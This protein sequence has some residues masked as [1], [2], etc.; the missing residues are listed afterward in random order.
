MTVNNYAPDFSRLN[1]LLGKVC[2][3]G[4]KQIVQDIAN[5][6]TIE[7]DPFVVRSAATYDMF[8]PLDPLDTKVEIKQSVINGG[9]L[10]MKKFLVVED[11]TILWAI[12]DKNHAITDFAWGSHENIVDGVSEI[13][14]ISA[15]DRQSFFNFLNNN[16]VWLKAQPHLQVDAK[17]LIRLGSLKP[18]FKSYHTY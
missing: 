16:P 5:R 12:K 7:G 3:H 13:K 14:G 11:V 1:E 15:A 18:I 4:T 10:D 6:V 2:K 17:K 8:H 9:V